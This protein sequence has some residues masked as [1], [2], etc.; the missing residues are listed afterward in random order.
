MDLLIKNK[1]V[2]LFDLDDTLYLYNKKDNSEYY[3]KVRDFLRNLKKQNKIIGLITNNLEPVG[4]LNKIGV[5]MSIFD[6]ISTP[7]KMNDFEYKNFC[8]NT[9]YS[10]FS[11]TFWNDYWYVRYPKNNIILKYIKDS[12]FLS[13]DII[14][15]DNSKNTIKSI[16]NIDC[17]L[18]N[19]ETGIEI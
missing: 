13:E 12:C 17:I 15:F 9:E 3:K 5:D 18:V 2:F 16:K 1:K 14:Y 19:P 11:W 8:K 10:S 4:I 6:I 7:I